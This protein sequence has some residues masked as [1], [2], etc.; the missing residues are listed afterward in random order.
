MKLTEDAVEAAAKSL[1]L[2]NRPLSDW[3]T[4]KLQAYWRG[5][6]RAALTAAA[7]FIAAEAWDAAVASLEYPDGSKVEVAANNNPYRSSE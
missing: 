1:H 3:D 5:E 7:P 2:K 4:S 6:A